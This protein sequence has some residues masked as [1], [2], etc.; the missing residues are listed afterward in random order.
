MAL[1]LTIAA[2]GFTAQAAVP[3]TMEINTGADVAGIST[4]EAQNGNMPVPPPCLNIAPVLTAQPITT[5]G[6]RAQAGEAYTIMKMIPALIPAPDSPDYELG[7]AELMSKLESGDRSNGRYVSF[8]TKL[9]VEDIIQLPRG[10]ILV[11]ALIVESTLGMRLA[12]LQVTLES[13]DSWNGQ[14]QNSLGAVHRFSDINYSSRAVGTRPG[15]RIASGQ[16]TQTF[17]KFFFTGF[18]KN[19]AAKT[20][21]DAE[22]ARVYLVQQ[23]APFTVTAGYDFLGADDNSVATATKPWSVVPQTPRPGLTIKKFNQQSLLL[24]VNG[25]AYAVQS[26]PTVMGGWTDCWT[27]SDSTVT[28]PGSGKARYFRSR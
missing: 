17:N 23:P 11:F 10:K 19:Y 3:R 18:G 13:N 4:Q 16:P 21:A 24:I 22:N 14:S 7:L 27:V 2:S 20:Q 1:A 26:S 12:D 6:I 9:N 15:V 5:Q 25:G 28:I 8:P